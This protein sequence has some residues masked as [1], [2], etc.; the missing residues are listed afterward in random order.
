MK[1]VVAVE[2]TYMTS[3]NVELVSGGIKIIY[4]IEGLFAEKGYIFLTSHKRA[5]SCQV[6]LKYLAT[7]L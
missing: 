6:F 7:I 1:T 3:V 2:A 4:L 5:V